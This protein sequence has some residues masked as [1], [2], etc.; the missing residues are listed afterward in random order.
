MATYFGFEPYTGE[1]KYVFVSYK[2]EE[3]EIA[4]KY[5]KY[6]H[7]N[8]VNVYYDAALS[9]GDN[10]A[11]ELLDAVKRE[12]CVGVVFLVSKLAVGSQPIIDEITR[13]HYSQKPILAVYIEDVPNL[14]EPL[15]TYLSYTQSVF[16]W[17]LDDEK[18][19]EAVLSGAKNLIEGNKAPV[20]RD[21][22]IDEHWKT[23]QFFL[24]NAKRGAAHVA[25]TGERFPNFENDI[26]KAQNELKQMVSAS[27]TD[28]RGWLGLALCE[29]MLGA[30][31]LDEAK[32]RF[33]AAAANYSY[34]MAAQADKLA[35]FEYTEAK[36]QMWRGVLRLI[37]K[38][39]SS[40]Q[41][42]KTSLEVLNKNITALEHCFGHTEPFVRREYDALA[43]KVKESISYLTPQIIF[44]YRFI[45]S[46]SV[47]I[48][49]YNGSDS[50]V[51]IPSEAEGKR[52]VS[53][54]ER[55]FADNPAVVSVTVPACVESIGNEAFSG[56][57]S[58]VD[59]FLP[60]KVKFGNAV[61][62]N[63]G[64]VTL[65]STGKLFSTVKSYAAKNG[66]MFASV[67]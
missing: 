39:L 8:G 57:V 10:W 17:K 26:S 54:A 64:N 59:A 36:T 3:T 4:A 2:S 27:P 6:L 22:K 19:H 52:V 35:S 28:Y 11:K 62:K 50:A 12:N 37:E 5:A 48:V 38:E 32:Q 46:S 66:I 23:A 40:A 67:K 31:S 65:H 18:A 55:A 42:N 34:V 49:K 29:C 44:E 56:C 9:A 61:F 43:A 14:E 41:N 13:A 47:E 60:D 53:I 7:N 20:A 45:S 15:K 58:L 33:S 25:S 30:C 16:A 21:T 51:T 24:A 63:C 1:E